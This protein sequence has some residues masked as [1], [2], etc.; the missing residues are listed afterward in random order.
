MAG[1]YNRQQVVARLRSECDAGR[2]IY[3]ALCGTGI[4]AKMA[5]QSFK[6]IPLPKA[7]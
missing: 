1:K 5:A 4:T 7:G 3:D 2:V 6:S